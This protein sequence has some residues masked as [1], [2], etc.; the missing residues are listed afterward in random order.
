MNEEEKY[1]VAEDI[2]ISKETVYLENK[3]IKNIIHGLYW[4]YVKIQY[5]LK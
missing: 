5:K 1:N 3:S 4:S 2:S